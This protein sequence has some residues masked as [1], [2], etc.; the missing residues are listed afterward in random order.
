MGIDN[1]DADKLII[2]ND[3]TLGSSPNMVFYGADVAI[4]STTM[5]PTTGSI[6]PTLKISSDI[7]GTDVGLILA[8]DTGEYMLYSYNDKFHIVDTDGQFAYRLTI[9]SSGNVN[10]PNQPV[11]GGGRNAGYMTDDQVWI[12]DYLNVNIGS[13]Y[14]TSNGRFTAPVAGT[15]HF[16]NNMLTADGSGNVQ[17]EW[18]FRK[19]GSNVKSFKK[20]DISMGHLKKNN[21]TYLTHLLF[22]GKVS[23][24]LVFTSIIFFLHALFPICEIPNKWD[25]KSTNNKLSKWNEYAIKRKN[26]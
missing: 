14:N 18:H 25:L 8:P 10:T 15:Y 19:N 4:G 21:E 1:S 23:L 7:S 26:K 22:A 13:H 11:F 6:G 2:S 12:C 17:A 3:T 5:G 16:N 24:T 9:D 20:V